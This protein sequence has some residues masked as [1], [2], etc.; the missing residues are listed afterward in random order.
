VGAP[1]LPLAFARLSIVRSTVIGK[2][3]TDS[4]VLAEDSIFVGEV[5]VA[6]RQIG[7]MRFCSVGQPVRTPRR[8]HCQ[9]DLVTAA[10]PAIADRE[11]RRVEPSFTNLRYGSPGYCQ[12]SLDCAQEITRGASDESEMGAFHDLFQPQRAANLRVRLDEYTPAGMRV[13]VLFAN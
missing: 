10:N 6:R 8:Y 2:V 11:A 4:I 1:D 9:P 7:C 5:R 13:E 3:D 12:L